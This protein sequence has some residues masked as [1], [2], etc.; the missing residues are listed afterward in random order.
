MPSFHSKTVSALTGVLQP[1]NLRE[2]LNHKVNG[3]KATKTLCSGH[4]QVQTHIFNEHDKGNVF[5]VPSTKDD[6]GKREAMHE[7]KKKV[8][9]DKLEKLSHLNQSTKQEIDK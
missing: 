8:Q 4:I 3:K 9:T 2:S 7:G 1:E 5:S 6:M